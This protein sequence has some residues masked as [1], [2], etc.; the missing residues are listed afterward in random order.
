MAEGLDLPEAA[1]FAES[2]IKLRADYRKQAAETLIEWSVPQVTAKLFERIKI[3]LSEDMIDR[4]F[5]AYYEPLAAIIYV[6]D[7]ALPVV[8]QI[9]S[10]YGTVGL[11]SNTI[12]P[13][14]A[15][16]RELEK[17]KL[18]PFFDFMIFSSTFGLRKPHPDI[19]YEASTRAGAAP[20]EC[21]YIGDRY[22]EDVEGPSGIGMHSI[23]RMH[24]DREYPED[25]LPSVRTINNLSELSLHL[26]I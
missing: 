22:R 24:D 12:F 15:H 11:V 2:Y 4:F 1:V 10:R 9:K 3:T 19:F 7:D 18:R 5:D 16:V 17:F 20:R 23:L 21:V 14:R 13:A 6:Y 25:K 8:E 26:D